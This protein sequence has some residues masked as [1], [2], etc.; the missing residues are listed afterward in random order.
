MTAA[1]FAAIPLIAAGTPAAHATTAGPATAGA[2]GAGRDTAHQEQK[3]Q[4]FPWMNPHQPSRLRAGELVAAMTLDQKITELHGVQNAQHRRYIPGIP[5][6]DIPPFVITNGPAGVGP[7]DDPQQQPATALPA[8]ISLAASFDTRLARQYGVITGSEARDLGNSLVEGPDV[9]MARVPENGRTFEGYG[10]DPYLTGQIGTADI[11]GVQSPRI[12]AEVKHYDANNQETNRNG[13]NEIIDNRTLH[14]IYLTQ[15]QAIIADAHPGAI[16]C[17]YPKVNGTYN[18][19]NDYLLKTVLHGQWGFNGF[20]Q[21][22]F[23]AAQSTVGSAQAGMDLEM[24]TGVY[25]ADA[26]KQAVENGQVSIATVNEFLIRRFTVMFQFGLFDR[27]LTTS[28]IPAATDGVFARSAAEEGTVLLKNQNA[29]LPLSANSISSI[30]VIGPYAGAAKTGGGGSSHVDPLY[31]VSPVAGIQS[32]AGPGVTVSYDDGSDPPTAAALAAKSDVAIVMVGDS[33]TEGTDRKT[34]ALSGDQDQLV[35]AVAAAN[36][37]T[38]VVVKSGGP[39]L[40]PWAGNVPAIVESWYPGEEDGNAVAAVLFGDVDPSGKL[41]ITFPVSDSQTPASTPQQW[42]GTNDTAVYSE[43]L[44][45]GYRWYQSQHLTPLFPFGFGLSYTTFAFSHLRVSASGTVSFDITNTGHRAG[46]DV[47]QAYV[48][49][50]PVAAEPLQQLQGFARVSLNPGQSRH[51]VIR[52]VPRAFQIWD[53]T[54]QRWTTVSGKYTISVGDS[55]VSLPLS[56][57]TVR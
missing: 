4:S 39:V 22:D 33:E 52:L 14:E 24:P 45:I 30:A 50:P 38:I 15:F 48:S 9:N 7:G 37:H 55:S 57:T 46:A 21:S 47:A 8:P 44:D 12:I 1:A 36:A 28:P 10:E 54:A 51:V 18:C 49:D 25:Y 16:M 11:E 53:T 31:T 23:G 6:L 17:A 40:M 27:P 32:R 56:A 34:L 2:T 3:P 20:V 13:V 42:P 35:A 26:M 19:E 5:Q 29:Q 41:P 43:G